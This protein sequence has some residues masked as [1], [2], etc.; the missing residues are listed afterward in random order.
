MG[1]GQRHQHPAVVHLVVE[2]D[3]RPAGLPGQPD[4]GGDIPGPD[5]VIGRLAQ[6]GRGGRGDGREPLILSCHRALLCACLLGLPPAGPLTCVKT[7]IIGANQPVGLP[8]FY[9]TKA[10]I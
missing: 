8:G 4:G 1:R 6:H 9:I 10:N 2:P 3:R 5:D 7:V